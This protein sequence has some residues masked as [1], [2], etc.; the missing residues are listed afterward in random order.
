MIVQLWVSDK[1]MQTCSWLCFHALPEGGDVRRYWRCPLVLVTT[2]QSGLRWLGLFPAL[3]GGTWKERQKQRVIRFVTPAALSTPTSLNLAIFFSIEKCWRPGPETGSK[4]ALLG[5]VGGP[6]AAL[7]KV[8]LQL[9]DMEILASISSDT[10][11]Y[12][13]RIYLLYR[14]GF[15]DLCR[16]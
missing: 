1:Q 5:G 15:I 2:G 16:M 8:I 7:L 4:Q 9:W 3:S 6:P 10:F 11:S 12:F 14:G 13:I